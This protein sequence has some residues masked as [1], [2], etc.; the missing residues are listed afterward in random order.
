MADDELSDDEQDLGGLRETAGHAE[1]DEIE[2]LSRHITSAAHADNTKSSYEGGQSR[3]FKWL[4]DQADFSSFLIPS[5]IVETATIEDVSIPLPE[6]LMKR[7][8][9]AVT[10]RDTTTLDL[11]SYS[12]V[13]AAI[14]A[15]SNMHIMRGSQIPQDI[16][17]VLNLHKKGVQRRI[18]Q[19]KQQGLRKLIDGK[20]PA[21]IESYKH[22]CKHACTYVGSDINLNI[23]CWLMSTLLFSLMCRCNNASKISLAHIALS[24]SKDSITIVL[25]VTKGDQEGFKTYP[26]TV[27]DNPNDPYW[28]VYLAFFVHVF[29]RSFQTTDNIN[30]LFGSF[31]YEYD[32]FKGLDVA[33][34]TAAGGGEKAP[35]CCSVCKQPGHNKSTCPA[36]SDTP[37]AVKANGKTRQQ[38]NYCRWMHSVFGLLTE[39]RGIE[40]VRSNIGINP[41]DIAAHS[42]RKGVATFLGSLMDWPSMATIFMRASWSMGNVQNRYIFGGGGGVH[43]P[44]LRFS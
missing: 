26:R 3:F 13:A 10:Y 40:W 8:L 4:K 16:Q 5:A 21:S 29:T 14:A 17:I 36:A 1:L 9:V 43:L 19:L 32:A 23:S 20:A 44:L 37:K 41:D 39:E 38:N 28:S 31:E 11:M 22:L 35:R 30:L 7:F 2:K 27:H 6:D 33:G 18:N 42:W 34:T 24:P 12:T 15:I 25:P